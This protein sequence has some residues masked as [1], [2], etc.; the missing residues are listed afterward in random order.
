[1]QV[2]QKCNI[3]DMRRA[4]NTPQSQCLLFIL[5]SS[6]IIPTHTQAS[7][8][9]CTYAE[10]PYREINQK[11]LPFLIR[12]TYKEVWVWLV[13]IQCMQEKVFLKII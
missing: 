4:K 5:P 2:G 13:E 9:A 10:L 6:L 8:T 11:K 3:E 1:M 12:D 7:N